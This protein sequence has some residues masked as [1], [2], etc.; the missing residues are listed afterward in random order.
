MQVAVRWKAFFQVIP[1]VQVFCEIFSVTPVAPGPVENVVLTSMETILQKSQ[2]FVALQ[3]NWTAP[4]FQGEGITG[5]QIWLGREPASATVAEGSLQEVG[6]NSRSMES[7]A[8]FPASVHG[9][10]LY[11]QVISCNLICSGTSQIQTPSIWGSLKSFKGCVFISGVVLYIII[12]GT[13]H[14]FFIDGDIMGCPWL[15]YHNYSTC[16]QIQILMCLL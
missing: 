12:F 2:Y 14:C 5:F 6:V 15:H 13:D 9:F 3:Y 10:H 8:L 7:Q 1:T 4:T 11:L 16:I